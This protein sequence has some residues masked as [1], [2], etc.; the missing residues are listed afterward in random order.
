MGKGNDEQSLLRSLSGMFEAGDIILGDAFFPTY[1]FL[2]EMLEKGVDILM[3]QYGARRRTT[4]FRRGVSLG[5]RDH[6]IE[7]SKPIRKPDWIDQASFDALP[8]I[9]S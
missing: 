7:S 1:L 8:D 3:E 4:D 9:I 2:A 6:I 5:K